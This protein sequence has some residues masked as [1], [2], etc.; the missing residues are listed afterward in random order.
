M[1]EVIDYDLERKALEKRVMEIMAVVK[2]H[3]PNVKLKHSYHEDAD[4]YQ[5]YVEKGFWRFD[6]FKIEVRKYQ[7]DTTYHYTFIV[8][9][10][11]REKATKIA[12]ELGIHKLMVRG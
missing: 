6:S 12:E 9:P 10:E 5:I 3:L 7:G 8:D 2:K 11:Y 4:C 1:V